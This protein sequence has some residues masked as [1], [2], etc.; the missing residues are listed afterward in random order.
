M[1]SMILRLYNFFNQGN[2][3]LSIKLNK[4]Q[5]VEVDSQLQTYYFYINGVYDL[6][7]LSPSTK[8]PD[9]RHGDVEGKKNRRI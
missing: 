9:V 7:L 3:L 8:A 5:Y 6:D 1:I 4:S 2:C